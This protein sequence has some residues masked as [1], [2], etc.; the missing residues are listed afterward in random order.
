MCVVSVVLSY[1]LFCSVWIPGPENEGWK[2]V[3]LGGMFIFVQDM[4]ERALAE[5]FTGRRIATP[6][7]YLHQMP[8][9][10]WKSDL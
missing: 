10:C 2:R 6:G 8:Y 3:Y 7:V 5:H 1:N 4:V 9:P